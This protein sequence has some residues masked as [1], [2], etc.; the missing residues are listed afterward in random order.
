M[1]VVIHNLLGI[2]SGTFCNLRQTPKRGQRIQ[3]HKCCNHNYSNTFW[4]TSMHNNFSSQ[5]FK[6]QTNVF[7]SNQNLGISY[8]SRE[9]EN[10][11]SHIIF[12][13][14]SL[15]FHEFKLAKQNAICTMDGPNIASTILQKEPFSFQL[16]VLVVFSTHKKV[17]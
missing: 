16:V 1:S 2:L 14:T 9:R 15:V 6:I 17:F 7:P 8:Y 11:E 3:W 12:W 13:Q 10:H 5:K 4:N